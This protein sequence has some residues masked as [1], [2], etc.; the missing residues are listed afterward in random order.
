MEIESIRDELIRLAR[1]D[2]DVRQRLAE[3]SL[4]DG[5]NPLMALVHRRNGD[6]SSASRWRTSPS[7]RARRIS[8]SLIDSIST[9]VG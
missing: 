3:G 9:P 7:S 2:G 1:E 4:F 6:P 8:S 5:Y